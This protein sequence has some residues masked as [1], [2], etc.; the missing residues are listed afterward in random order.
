[1]SLSSV[2]LMARY[3]FNHFVDNF[4]DLHLSLQSINGGSLEDHIV[5][6]KEIVADLETLEVKYN[7]EDLALILLRSLPG[8]YASFLVTILYSQDTLTINDVYD[9]LHSKE[10]LKH[11]VGVTSRDEK[12]LVSHDG[13]RRG[14]S[15]NN[16]NLFCFYCRCMGHIRKDCDKLQVKGDLTANR[17][18]QLLT[19]DE[20]NRGI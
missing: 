19:S 8:F 13:R 12:A 11:L 7:E 6:F 1:M 16:N 15:K 20:T 5:V 2:K 18:A 10:K 4:Y 14:R 17:G 3:Q 9:V